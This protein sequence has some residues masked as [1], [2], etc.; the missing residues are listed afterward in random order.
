MT[1]I[2]GQQGGWRRSPWRLLLWA[3]PTALLI[4][5]AVAMQFT[6]EVQWTAFDF[7]AAFVMLFGTTGLIDLAIR[8]GGSAPY[9]LGAGLAVLI[10]FLL[11]WINGAVGFIGNED[12]PVNLVY[13]GEI[14]IAAVGA[15][16]AR[17][18]ARGMACAMFI[19]AAVQA[20][21]TVTALAVGLGAG[22]PP[23]AVGLAMLNGVFLA[24]WLICAG[25]FRMAAHR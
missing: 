16:M 9:K 18:E 1:A 10:S 6:A 20:L 13:I 21:V 25:L 3:I 7:V 24:L 2:S 14:L 11:V 12:N 17:F 23:G 4:L 19:T 15:T 8:K 22:D 5:P